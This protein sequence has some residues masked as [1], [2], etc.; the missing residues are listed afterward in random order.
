[1]DG[2]VSFMEAINIY[3]KWSKSGKKGP[4]PFDDYES[5]DIKYIQST[6]ILE[7]GDIKIKNGWIG[8]GGCSGVAEPSFIDQG[9]RSMFHRK[10]NKIT[11]ANLENGHEICFSGIDGDDEEG[12]IWY[13]EYY[14]LKTAQLNN[15]D[16]IVVELSELGLLFDYP[17]RDKVVFYIEAKDVRGFK[18]KE[19][20][21]AAFRYYHL[22]Y[23]L[24]KNYNMEQEEFAIGNGKGCF[25]TT[26]GDHY[27]DNGICALV[28]DKEMNMWSVAM[29]RYI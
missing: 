17:N 25:D 19:L 24:N 26:C 13:S 10:R 5:E 8:W 18:R 9:Y 22:L 7:P 1:M 23:Q 14:P 27:E 11:L 2:T 28:Y 4:G 3:N 12:G 29:M 21:D 20:L 16:D 6:G 15:P